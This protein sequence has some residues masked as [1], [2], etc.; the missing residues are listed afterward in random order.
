[1]LLVSYFACQHT[2]K[3]NENV[4]KATL[5]PKNPTKS[6]RAPYRTIQGKTVT[7]H[8]HPNHR[9]SAQATF[10]FPPLLYTCLMLAL[11]LTGVLAQPIDLASSSSTFEYTARRNVQLDESFSSSLDEYI[12]ERFD[13]ESAA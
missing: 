10:S 5:D 12:E 4:S 2:K 13:K 9:I 11:L 6:G 7:H 8:L 3:A 1:M